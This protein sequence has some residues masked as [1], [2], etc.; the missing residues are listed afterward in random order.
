MKKIAVLLS[1][2]GVYDGT[3]IQE[4]VSVLIALD[5]LG[6]EAVCV[7][8]NVP[9]HHVIDHLTGDEMPASRNVLE[10]SAR[11][12][13]GAVTD[14]AEVSAESLDGLI[15]PGGFGAAKNLSTWAFD[16][17]EA[18]VLPSVAALI[19]AM[20]AAG[21]PVAALCVAPVVVAKALAESGPAVSMTLGSTEDSSPYEIEG[22]HA[23]VASL[24][25]KP[26]NCLLGDIVVDTEHNVITS[27]CYMMEATPAR[28]LAG[29]RKA[30]AALLDLTS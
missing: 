6:A 28:I 14:L 10:E 13:R 12:A 5:E 23:G 19:Q 18:S 29:V 15:I 21:K 25:A 30:C 4:A 3:E 2:C 17:P 16:G 11:I 1:G 9:Q 7:A 22:F 8:P 24:G 20:V 27:P 26:V